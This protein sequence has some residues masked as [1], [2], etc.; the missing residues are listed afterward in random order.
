MVW[1][2]ITAAWFGL[3]WWLFVMS[4]LGVRVTERQY[5]VWL[6][7]TAAWFGLVS[8]LVFLLELLMSLL[9]CE[10]ESTSRS[11]RSP[12]QPNALQTTK[13]LVDCS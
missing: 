11:A 2:C 6:C 10:Q 3:V 8:W 9:D 5:M 4:L 1:L 13:Q 12:G 7:V